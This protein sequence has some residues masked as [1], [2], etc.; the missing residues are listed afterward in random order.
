MGLP[1]PLQRQPLE[2]LNRVTS[3]AGTPLHIWK[4]TGAGGDPLQQLLRRSLWLRL[5]VLG[6]RRLVADAH[7]HDHLVALS[8]AT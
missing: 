4:G 3:L 1:S 7:R 6:I 8:T 2:P 5:Q